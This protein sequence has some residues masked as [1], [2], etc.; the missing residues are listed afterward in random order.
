MAE[1]D[2]QYDFII[3]PDKPPKKPSFSFGSGLSGTMKRTLLF[4]TIFIIAITI[5]FVGLSFFNKASNAQS[6]RLTEIIKAQTEI[7]RVAQTAAEKIGDKQ[8]YNKALNVRLTTTS[9]QQETLEALDK[10]GKKLSEKE[11]V[12]SLDTNNDTLLVEAEQNDRFDQTYKELLDKQLSD[13]QQLLRAAY[14]SGSKS[15]KLTLESAFNQV[16]LISSKAA[17]Q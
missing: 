5:F 15:E 6:D 13:Y 17:S 3:N 4:G 8:L 10:R 16:D 9:A 7:I 11:L 14:D 1:L 12:K 2:H